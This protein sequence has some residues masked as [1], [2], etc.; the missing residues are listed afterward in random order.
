[1]PAFATHCVFALELAE[2]LQKTAD[3]KLNKSALLIGAQ[4][5]DIF[6]FHRALPWQ[7]GK[8]LRKV[9]SAMHRADPALLFDKLYEYCETAENKSVAKSYAFGFILHYSLDRICH[10]FV[11][12]LQNRITQRNEKE[13]P[14]CAHNTVEY[15]LD[16][17]M[18]S[19]Y[20]GE[21]RPKG[22]DTA[23]LLDYSEDEK[24]QCAKAVSYIS[25]VPPKEAQTAIDDMKNAQKLLIDANSEKVKAVS[26]IEKLAAPFTKNYRISSFFRTNDLETAEKYVNINRGIW[27]SPFTGELRRESFFDLYNTAKK[28]ALLLVRQWQEGVSGKENTKSISFLTGVEKE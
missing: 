13:N 11:Y 27:R 14:H 21:K 28:D 3:I 17:L 12:F 8:T 1:M 7:S 23:A 6:F 5:P 10:P 19:R 18:I 22:F 15:S 24:E 16:S 4:G 26:V 2:E 25:G 20:F 9:G